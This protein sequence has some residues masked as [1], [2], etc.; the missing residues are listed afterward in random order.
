MTYRPQ[1]TVPQL[2]NLTEAEARKRAE[3]LGLT[4]RV[5]GPG[6]N[7]ITADLSHS[8]VNLVISLGRVTQAK[9]Y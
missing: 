2:L 5:I 7:I 6:R 3:Q 1:Q 9:I 4:V 8:R